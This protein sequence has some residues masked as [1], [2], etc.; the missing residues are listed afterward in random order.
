MLGR[1]WVW[2]RSERLSNWILLTIGW[3]LYGLREE[4]FEDDPT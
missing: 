2:L 4:D 3:L 1:A